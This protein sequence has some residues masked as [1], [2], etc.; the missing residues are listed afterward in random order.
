MRKAII[1]GSVAWL[2]LV[3]S[4]N[5]QTASLFPGSFNQTQVQNVTIVDKSPLVAPIPNQQP[6]PSLIDRIFMQMNR[7]LH[8][9]LGSNPLA[10]VHTTTGAPVS[11]PGMVSPSLFVPQAPFTNR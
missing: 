7:F 8:P 4:A 1:S 2:A 9:T 3:G 10:E 6:Q 11:S 5:A